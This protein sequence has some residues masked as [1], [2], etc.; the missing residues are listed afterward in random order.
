MENQETRIAVIGIIIDD[1]NQ[2]EAVNTL[3]SQYGQYVIGR[4]GLPYEKKQVNIIS[5]VV[6]APMDAISA[7]SGKLGRLPGVSSKALYSKA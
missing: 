4:M 6:D 1:R 3:L 7:L 5:I 2:A